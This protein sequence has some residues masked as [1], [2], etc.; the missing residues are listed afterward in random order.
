M[1]NKQSPKLKAGTGKVSK[2]KATA[3]P[4]KRLC[5][6]CKQEIKTA[7]SLIKNGHRLLLCSEQCVL[8]MAKERGT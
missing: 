1:A 5:V 6:C 3:S 7:Y 2:I 4:A 8:K